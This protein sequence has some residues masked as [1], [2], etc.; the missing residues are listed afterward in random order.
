VRRGAAPPEPASRPG[1]QDGIATLVLPLTLWVAVLL[2]IALVDVGAYLVAASR[3]QALA[4][5]AA[6]AAVAADAPGERTR[7]P[8]AE[9]DR[10]VQAGDG[11]LERCDCRAGSEQA[12]VTVSV[13]VPGLIIPT[14]GASRVAADAAAVLAPP[15]GLDPGP[16]RERAG[17]PRPQGG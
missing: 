12:S 7:S 5:A 10:V 6:L 8:V 14:L 11:W 4:D 17:W 16:T 15:E 1:D 2:A 3:A 9:A 13:A